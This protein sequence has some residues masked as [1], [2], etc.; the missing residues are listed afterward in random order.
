MFKLSLLLVVLAVARTNAQFFFTPTQFSSGN[1]LGTH[2]SIVSSPSIPQSASYVSNPQ[3]ITDIQ[4]NSLDSVMSTVIAEAT[5]HVDST[6]GHR[7]HSYSFDHFGGGHGGGHGMGG[8]NY[9]KFTPLSEKIGRISNIHIRAY[10][11]LTK[12][13]QMPKNQVLRAL[14]ARLPNECYPEQRKPIAC[15]TNARYR[16]IDGT[17]NNLQNPYWGASY[18]VFDRLVP[19]VYEDGWNEPRGAGKSLAGA[20]LPNARIVSLSVHPD[21]ISPDNRMTNMVPQVGQFLDHDMT[22]T[23]ETDKHCCTTDASNMDC[24]SINIP[25]DDYF[26][27][28][29]RNPSTCMAFT[30]STAYCFPN[31]QGVREQFNVITAFV[32]ASH[33]YASEN[34]RNR[35]LRSHQGG[36]LRVNSQNPNFLPTVEEIQR[37]SGEKFEFMGTFYG[38]EERTNEMPALTVMHTLLFREHNRLATEIASRRP[39]WDDETIF[40]EA[41]R[42]LIAQWQNVIYGEYLPVILGDNTMVRYGLKLDDVQL[43]S[44]Y[45]PSTNPTVFH[46]FADAAYRFG[47]TL[48][49]GLIRMMKGFQDISSYRLRDA[50]FNHEQISMSGGQGY[51]FILNGL[52]QQNAQTYDPFITEEVTNFLLRERHQ[53]HGGDLIAR[54][55]QRGRDHGLPSYNVYRQVC[56]LQ[57][58]SNSWSN[59]PSNI[60]QD[61]WQ[62]LGSLY[63][64]PADIDL[65]TGGLAETP[66]TG[67]VTGHTFN[68]LKALQFARVRQGDRFFFTHRGNPAPFSPEQLRE[69]R[70][71]T[72]GDI[73]C[74]NSNIEMTT[75]NVF[76]IPSQDNP[77][78]YCNDPNR[79]RINIEVFLYDR[80]KK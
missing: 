29:L 79:N 12:R 58:I 34:G 56:G 47:H 69:I 15:D 78:M 13:Y 10:E 38:G 45:N 37:T 42:L 64:T 65:F 75:R 9:C 25:S 32:D 36:R 33:V 80:V 55:L 51:D 8:H 14:N 19:A 44:E 72:F 18:T 7:N 28:K 30:R 24:W 54:N 63:E 40:Q 41:R 62:V 66:V 53:D 52:M 77:M 74:D 27:S 48:I 31:L 60:P 4:D 39:Y 20:R 73:I 50:F 1:L 11:T 2:N 46:A 61:V 71:R 76:K 3:G 49:N 68:C 43:Y 21:H 35:L 26:F 6:D 16:T 17:C 5:Q 22:L 59:R 67:A 23:P 57:G 70:K